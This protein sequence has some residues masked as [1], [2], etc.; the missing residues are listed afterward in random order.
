MREKENNEIMNERKENEDRK[1]EKNTEKKRKNK[2]NDRKKRKW[3]GNSDKFFVSC[4]ITD[5]FPANRRDKFASIRNKRLKS[6]KT[7]LPLI[8][9][10][11]SIVISIG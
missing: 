10:S 2:R 8:D 7:F 11:A 6:A 4:G 1:K 9:T 5:L 3:K